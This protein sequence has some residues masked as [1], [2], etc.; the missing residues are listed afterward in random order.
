MP[1][2][3]T[4]VV[5]TT[6]DSNRAGTTVVVAIPDEATLNSSSVAPIRAAR[7]ALDD[8]PGV[9]GIAGIGAIQLDYGHAIFGNFPLMFGVVA[10]LTFL[11]ARP[12]VP[13][14]RAARRRRSC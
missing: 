13:L 10:V 11:A 8:E 5:P 9:S 7:D 2:I 1:G 3:A 4:A 14:G 6:A 12:R